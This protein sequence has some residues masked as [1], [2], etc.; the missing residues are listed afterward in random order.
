MRTLLT[1]LGLVLATP[2]LAAPLALPGTWQSS[3]G[4]PGT[5]KFHPS[6]RVDLLPQGVPGLSGR[7]VLTGEWLE[8]KPDGGREAATMRVVCQKPNVCEFTYSDGSKQQF[9]R[10]TSKAPK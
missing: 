1:C 3:T 8:I 10:Q 9:V 4:M 2:A 6:G 7:F 5:M